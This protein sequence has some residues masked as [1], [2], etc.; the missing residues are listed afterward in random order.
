M[1]YLHKYCEILLFGKL[2]IYFIVCI[3]CYHGY[4]ILWVIN[5]YCFIFVATVGYLELFQ[6]GSTHLFYNLIYIPSDLQSYD[7]L[8]QSLPYY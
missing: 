6:M 5:Q 3:V 7:S 8:L 2:I 4:F 1:W